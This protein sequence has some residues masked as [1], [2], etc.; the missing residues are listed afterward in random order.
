MISLECLYCGEASEASF[1][2]PEYNCR[3]MCRN[4][5][6]HYTDSL[7]INFYIGI[8]CDRCNGWSHLKCTSIT[9]SEELKR[10]YYCVECGDG[11]Y[12]D[13][14]LYNCI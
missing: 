10:A 11:I 12:S 13:F 8:Q 6:G 4:F 9:S 1:V 7:L 5:H 3:C 2:Y 14:A